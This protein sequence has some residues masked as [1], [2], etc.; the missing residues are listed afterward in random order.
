MHIITIID[1]CIYL[2][3][4]SLQFFNTKCQFE[5]AA[6]IQS[7]ESKLSHL[8]KFSLPVGMFRY[9]PDEGVL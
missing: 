2:C 5:M 3:F 9:L 6:F 8:Q 1:F 7:S 4:T